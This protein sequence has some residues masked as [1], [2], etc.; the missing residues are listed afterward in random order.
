MLLYYSTT[1]T[2]KTLFTQNQN[3][4]QFSN[5]CTGAVVHLT[6]DSLVCNAALRFLCVL[7]NTHSNLLY[8][9]PLQI[10]CKQNFTVPSGAD[11]SPVSSNEC[12]NFFLL[13]E[14]VHDQKKKKL[15]ID[16]NICILLQIEF[17]SLDVQLFSVITVTHKEQG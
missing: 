2:F 13:L 15:L 11:H 17:L 5:A 14:N 4:V 6:I 7:E 9:I 1:N 8:C 12:L 16:L 10:T 3:K